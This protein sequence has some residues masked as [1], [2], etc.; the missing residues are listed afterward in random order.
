MAMLKPLFGFDVTYDI[1]NQTF[2]AD[3]FATKKVDEAIEK[4]IEEATVAIESTVDKAKTPAFFTILQY[5]SFYYSL[6]VIFSIFAKGLGESFKNAPVICITGIAA[7]V[8][9][10]GLWLYS[11]NKEKTLPLQSLK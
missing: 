7:L 9:A 6:I 4:S 11:K 2:Y 10:I 1:N 5:C 8:L 3:K